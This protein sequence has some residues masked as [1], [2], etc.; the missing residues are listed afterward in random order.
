MH[1]FAVVVYVI[2]GYMQEL[3]NPAGDEAGPL[4]WNPSG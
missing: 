4:A 3:Q 2:F 1:L